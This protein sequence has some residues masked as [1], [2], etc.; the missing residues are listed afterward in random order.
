MW[1]CFRGSGKEEKTDFLIQ[2]EQMAKNLDIL[3][4]QKKSIIFCSSDFIW[5]LEQS[6]FLSVYCVPATV[7][8]VRKIKTLNKATE[9]AFQVLIAK[10][11][12]K[13]YKRIVYLVVM[14]IISFPKGQ[15]EGS[16]LLEKYAGSTLQ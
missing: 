2:Y 5:Y 9:F 4:P 3:A 13:T 10:N 15:C 8:E 6:I 11:G 1:K 16:R 12:I 14:R 7:Q